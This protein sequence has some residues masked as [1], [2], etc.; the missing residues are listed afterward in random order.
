MS[1]S[2][3]TFKSFHETLTTTEQV[4]YTTPFGYTTVVLLAQ[5]ANTSSSNGAGVTF[6]SRDGDTSTDIE[7]VESYVIAP[8]DAAGLLTG[9]LVVESGNSI[10]ALSDTN[11]IVKLTISVLETLNE[12]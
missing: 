2:L 4:I 3:N 8:T 1:T 12:S 11:S 6:I 7:L 9:K 5:A 10:V